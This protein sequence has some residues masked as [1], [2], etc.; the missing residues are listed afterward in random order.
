MAELRSETPASEG[1]RATLTSLKANPPP[2]QHHD[3]MM[4]CQWDPLP[5]LTGK[6]R[7]EYPDTAGQGG[8]EGQP[9]SPSSLRPFGIQVMGRTSEQGRLCMTC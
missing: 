6:T 3:A 7:T 5:P 9:T 2:I 4:C 1:G 8:R